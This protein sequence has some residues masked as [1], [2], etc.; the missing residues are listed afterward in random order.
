MQLRGWTWPNVFNASGA[1][2]FHGEGYWWHEHMRPLGLD[3][4][5]SCFVS[6]TATAKARKGNMPLNAFGA[7]RELIPSCIIVK[8]LK[9]VVLNAVGLTNPG[10]MEVLGD[11]NDLAKREP[12][13]MVS[14]AALGMNEAQEREE[15]LLLAGSLGQL[16]AYRAAGSV[17]LQL[18]ISCPNMG[19]REEEH[20]AVRANRQLTFLQGLSRLGAVPILL[21]LNIL[22]PTETALSL[23]SHPR[24]DGLVVSNSL[25]WGS[26]PQSINWKRLFGSDT[27]PLAHLGGGGLSG[28]PLLPLVVQWLLDLR[29]KSVGRETGLKPI[30]AGGGVLSPEDAREL[31][32]VGA[33]AIELGSVSI[34]RPWRVKKIIDYVNHTIEARA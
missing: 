9:G 31:I 3:Y 22:T 33:A 28:R 5:G 17:G 20:Y 24:C 30:I 23:M 14:F 25:P 13:V 15:M 2:G 7:P 8:P 1:R 4:G 32:Y 6:K 34:L 26:Y 21:K 11:V 18:N 16:V 10:V 29:L 19:V 27:S 12:R